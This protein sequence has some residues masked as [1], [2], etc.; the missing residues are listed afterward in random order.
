MI[1]IE[2]LG[3]YANICNQES[4]S[5]CPNIIS[6]QSTPHFELGAHEDEAL[7]SSWWL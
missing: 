1:I 5:L 6:F 4:L 7:Q 2:K 3:M